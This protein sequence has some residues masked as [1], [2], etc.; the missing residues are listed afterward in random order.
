MF[1]YQPFKTFR[2]T[3]NSFPDNESFEVTGSPELHPTSF[4]I[5]VIISQLV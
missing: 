5:Q 1:S 2:G 3:Y 4:R